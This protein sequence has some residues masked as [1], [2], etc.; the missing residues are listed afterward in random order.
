MMI[1]R[2]DGVTVPVLALHFLLRLTCCRGLVHLSWCFFLPQAKSNLFLI[3]NCFFLLEELGQDAMMSNSAPADA[4]HYR[5]EGKLLR[6]GAD[7][8]ESPH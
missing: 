2:Y 7:L 8:N 4:E 1:V 5:I 3:N 6:C